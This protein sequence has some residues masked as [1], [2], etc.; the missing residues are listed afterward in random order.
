M[1]E[2]ITDTWVGIEEAAAYLGVT[3]DTVRNW[4][5]KDSGIPAVKIGKMWKF[6]ISELDEWVKSGKGAIK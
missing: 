6:K 1:K 2:F 5:K 4:I 3:K